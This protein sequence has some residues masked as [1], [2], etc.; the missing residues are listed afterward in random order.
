MFKHGFTLPAARWVALAS[1]LAVVATAAYADRSNLAGS[2]NAGSPS[3]KSL[4]GVKQS[5]VSNSSALDAQPVAPGGP[6][7]GHDLH[8]DV[9]PDLSK[10]VPNPPSPRN[11][12]VPDRDGVTRPIVDSPRVQDPVTQKFMQAAGATGMPSPIRN[13]DGIYNYWGVYPPDTNGDVGPNNYVQIVND[14]F[15]V[16]SKTGAS[17]YGPANTNTLFKGFGGVCE[18]TNDGDPIAL[19]DPLADRWLI[20]QFAVPGGADG[21]HQC[22]AISTTGDPT[23]SYYR[24]DFPISATFLNDYPKFGV[25]P[26]GYYVSFNMFRSNFVGAEPAVLDRASMLQGRAATFQYFPADRKDAS[27]LPADFDGRLLP[28]AGEP[29]IFA[30][31]NGGRHPNLGV[32][33]F[34]VDWLNPANS[35]FTL[36][37]N[38]PV[39]SFNYPCSS[40]QGCIPQ[41]G[42]SQTLDSLGDRLMY[43][44]QYRNLGDHQALVTNHTVDVAANNGLNAGVRWYELR[45][46]AGSS[47][48]PSLYQQGT[49]APDADN[50][51]MGSAAMDHNGDIAV[52]YSVSS[53]STYPSIRYAGRL[54]TDP[55]GILAQGETSLF[56]G[57]GSETGPEG[58]WGDYSML[59]VDPSDDCTFW[60]TTEY[61]SQ[62]GD[63]DWRTRIGSFKFAGC[64]AGPL[65]TPTRGPRP[66]NTPAPS[67]TATPC[68]GG[69]TYNG[70]ITT[71]DPVANGR[72]SRDGVPSTCSVAKSCPGQYDGL[73]RHY[74]SYTYHNTTASPQCVTVHIT[75]VC[76]NNAL[77]S[78]AYLGSF[79]PN[80]LC[81]NYLAD[82][83]EAGPSFSYSFN[84]PAGSTVVVMVEENTSNVG[85]ASYTLQ[86]NP[87][88]VP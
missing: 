56:A 40:G 5:S 57:S 81:A 8:H 50:R 68:P 70:S 65:P 31:I 36:S 41:P 9:S 51:W 67:P 52:G 61:L 37:A 80:N 55:L 73:A 33:N 44:L 49:F 30:E 35:T 66:T 16:Y 71:S 38:V 15:Q 86:I 10:I 46:P 4:S 64:S 45:S 34:H 48:V 3:P 26:D 27:L 42:T 18:R 53:S 22:V 23:G 69:T 2:G 6:V 88:S 72:L 25:W 14:G 47:F 77:L 60:Y 1:C 84:A 7:V 13:F 79:D 29:E 78:A 12:E 43:R 54:S 58:R 82:M 62:T 63:R 83:G 85:C 87:C 59:A 24:Y 28:P 20:S 74:D 17:L 19:Y 32:Y 75:E 76:G 39:A 11:G 21:Y